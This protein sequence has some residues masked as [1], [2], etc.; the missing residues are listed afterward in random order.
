MIGYIIKLPSG[1]KLSW[2]QSYILRLIAEDDYFYENSDWATI[3]VLDRLKLIKFDGLLGWVLTDKGKEVVRKENPKITYTGA[4]K[5]IDKM[6][7][8]LEEDEYL[9]IDVVQIEEEIK[10][11][12]RETAEEL[13]DKIEHDILR[14]IVMARGKYVDEEGKQYEYR[15]PEEKLIFKAVKNAIRKLRLVAER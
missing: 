14:R 7:E 15:S 9:D 2:K 10:E 3:D 6:F 12:K 8:A 1:K 13:A 5:A 11:I 4:L